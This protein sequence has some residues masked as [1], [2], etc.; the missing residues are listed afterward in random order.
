LPFFIIT[1]LLW[2]NK[3]KDNYRKY[4]LS[5]EYFLADIIEFFQTIPLINLYNTFTFESIRL[6]QKFKEL[7]N[8]ELNHYIIVNKR[9]TYSKI[10]SSLTPVYLAFIAYIFI[11]SNLATI[12]QIFAFWGLFS[13]TIGAVSGMSSL[14]TSLLNALVVFERLQNMIKDKIAKNIKQVSIQTLEQIQCN[15]ISFSYYG[16]RTKTF[17]IPQVCLQKGK[18]TEIR[19]DS[20][21]GKTTLIKLVFGLLRPNKGE[22]LING[23]P[24]NLIDKTC[25]LPKIGYVEQNGYIYSRSLKNN[26]TLGREFDKS[27]WNTSISLAALDS[28]IRNLPLRQNQPLGEN[29]LQ[30]S[31]GERQRILIARALYHSPQWLFLDEPFIGIDENNQNQIEKLIQNI[32]KNI[33]IVLI[34]HQKKHSIKIDNLIEL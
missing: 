28:F 10:I 20:G 1:F 33:T 4:R 29:G 23:T 34:T 26:I 13:L 11:A 9:Q 16:D 3:I 22:I 27:A 24:L 18:Q 25:Y 21:V 17:S 32:S 19:G 14:Y 5:S 31:G 6:N 2:E 12:G 15:N 30:V 8:S 7:I